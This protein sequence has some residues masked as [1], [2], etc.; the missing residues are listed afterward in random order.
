MARVRS[1]EYDE[2]QASIL[3]QAAKLFA[4][5]GFAR[6]SISELSKECNASKAWIY[7]Y[8]ESKEAILYR[9]L[10]RH[11][12]ELVE[13]LIIEPAAGGTPEAH[14]GTL[15]E[16]LLKVYEDADDTHRVLLGDLHILPPDQRDSIRG[17]ER[18]IVRIFAD[19]IAATAPHLAGQP[20]LLKPV[21]MSLFG[22]LNWHYTWFKEGG[23]L[24]RG[25]YARLT[26]QLFL[27][28]VKAVD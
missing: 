2:K 1:Q 10:D 16:R 21:T 11:M 26:T 6:T 14:L 12:R 25:D 20:E 13:A 19:A 23:P 9:I 15:V 18:Q 28:G 22:M 3:D 24:S 8:Y 5:N 7:H 27:N 4:R 17:M